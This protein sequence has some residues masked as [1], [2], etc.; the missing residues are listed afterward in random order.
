MAKNDHTGRKI[1]LSAAI[2]GLMGYLSGLFTAP[3]S[4]QATRR[5]IANKAEDVKETAAEQLQ[6]ANDELQDLLK[7]AKNK[8]LSLSSRA[9]EEFNEAVVKG[10]DA[11]DKASK[12]LKAIKA[13]EADDPELNKSV[14]Q[15]RSAVKNLRRYLKS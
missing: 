12:V 14:K 9:R 6:D 11:Q 5:G 4:G 7:S 2:G 3:K 1:A 15:A 10:K 13:G 8:S